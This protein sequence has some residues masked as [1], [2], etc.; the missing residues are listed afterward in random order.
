M[1]ALSSA[2][3]LPSSSPAGGAHEL[4][5][6][7]TT[8]HHTAPSFSPRGAR[9]QK[10][11]SKSSRRALPD[12]HPALAEASP[13]IA[14]MMEADAA[15]AASPRP[16]ARGRP[17]NTK[18]A[19][20]PQA[21]SPNAAAHCKSPYWDPRHIAPPKPPKPSPPP[22][23]LHSLHD[24]V[25]IFGSLDVLADNAHFAEPDTSSWQP[26]ALV[27]LGSEG[28]GKS[29]LLERLSKL[30]IFPRAVDGERGSRLTLKLELRHV[31]PRAP[32]TE[33][34]LPQDPMYSRPPPELP[35]DGLPRQAPLLAQLQVPWHHR[36]PFRTA[37][38]ITVTSG[39]WWIA[40][41]CPN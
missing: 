35:V 18:P 22:E 25:D 14:A 24:L 29:A 32:T 19:R 38:Q 11:S 6:P 10:L 20:R 17:P 16:P 34:H 41:D 33:A 1:Q 31:R 15:T 3:G 5:F 37:P 23:P 12:G 26:P 39:A 21:Y 36:V 27:A 2:V 8:M 7:P 40:V 9:F 28:S 13:L 30:P 4:A